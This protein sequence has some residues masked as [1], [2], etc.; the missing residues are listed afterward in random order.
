MDSLF[1]FP[2]GL[3][4]P[5]QHAGLSRRTPSCRNSRPLWNCPVYPLPRRPQPCRLTLQ[6]LPKYEAKR[7]SAETLH[8]AVGWSCY[9]NLGCVLNLS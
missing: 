2:V 1:S 6:P 7:L 3:F 5:L 9:A 8:Y 4:H